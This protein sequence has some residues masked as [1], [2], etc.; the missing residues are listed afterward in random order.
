MYEILVIFCAQ[1][2]PAAAL[3]A[4]AA[5]WL[6]APRAVKVE[7]ALAALVA[8]P[9]AY[10]VARLAGLFFSHEQPFAAYGYEPLVPH[11]VD[12]S[13]PSDHA[14][15][16]GALAA[17]AFFFN[18]WLSAF[19]LLCAALVGLA[20]VLIGFHY[21]LDVVAGLLLGVASAAVAYAAVHSYF[22]ARPHTDK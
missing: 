9:L 8:L 7:L 14:A 3:L 1:Y 11:E 15:A 6:W 5:Y 21:P 12:N 10:A 20:R 4:C 19:L 16:L 17:L 22:S 13:F 2:L 18:R